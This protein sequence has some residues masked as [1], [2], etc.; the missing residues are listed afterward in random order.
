VTGFEHRIKSVFKPMLA[1]QLLTTV[2]GVGL[3]LPS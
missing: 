1:I 2:P 3:T